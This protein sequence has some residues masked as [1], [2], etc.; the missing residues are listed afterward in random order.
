MNIGLIAQFKCSLSLTNSMFHKKEGIVYAVPTMQTT[1]H[2][3][4][5]RLGSYAKYGAEIVY[6]STVR[7]V[8]RPYDAES[9]QNLRGLTMNSI[10]C[11]SGL[12]N[13]SLCRTPSK[14]A[15]VII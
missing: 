7:H 15:G 14:K 12:I 6:T 13:L 3:A 1:T 10:S 2:F 5:R 9:D 4:Q 8:L 11:P